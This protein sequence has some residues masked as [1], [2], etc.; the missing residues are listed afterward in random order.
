MRKHTSMP[1]LAAVVWAVSIGLLAVAVR[2]QSPTEIDAGA[3]NRIEGAFLEFELGLLRPLVLSADGRTLW[4]INQPGAEIGEW[5]RRE[6]G[7][8]PEWLRGFPATPGL[9]SLHARSEARELWAVDRLLGMVLV[10]D[11]NRGRLMRGIHVGAEPHG[12]A[13]GPEGD[14]AYVTLAGEDAVAVLDLRGRSVGDYR[15]LH[16]IAIPAREPRGIAVALDRVWVAPL[17]SGNNTA[18]R[19]R[20]GNPADT[21]VEFVNAAAGAE[22][23]LPDHD[24][25]AITITEDP[26]TDA[27]DLASSFRGLGTTLFDVVPR[28]GTSEL[29]I[30]N[31]DALN[32]EVHGERGFIR[33]QVVN[34]RITIVNIATRAVEF[35]SLDPRPESPR[36]CAQPTGITFDAAGTTAYAVGYG[37]DLVA[38]LDAAARERVRNFE[39]PSGGAWRAGPRSAVLAEGALLV[40]SKNDQGL[41]VIDPSRPSSAP[42]RLP[43]GFDP[44]PAAIKRGRGQLIDASHSASGTSSCASCHI[45]GHLDGLV[46]D[47]SLFLDTPADGRPTLPIDRKGPMLTQSLRGLSELAP[48]HWRGEKQTLHDFNGAFVGLL[49]RE[50]PLASEDMD[51][52]VAYIQ[53][54]VHPAN[55][56]APINGSLSPLAAEGKETFLRESATTCAVCHRLPLGTQNELMFDLFGG[57]SSSFKVAPLRALADRASPP[58]FVGGNFGRNGV[59]ASLGGGFLHNGALPSLASFLD[60]FFDLDAGELPGLERFLLEI[61]SGIAPAAAR[62]AEVNPHVVARAELSALQAAAHAGECDLILL[63][64]SGKLGDSGSARRLYSPGQRAF[65]GSD[66][67][68]ESISMSEVI[69]SAL[70]GE[71]SWLV[72]GVP[73]GMGARMSYDR[74]SDELADALELLIGSDSELA[75]SDGD[76]AIDGYEWRLGGNPTNPALGPLPGASAPTILSSEIL[77]RT[78]NSARLRVQT[79]LPSV[80]EIRYSGSRGPTVL[81]SPALGGGARLHSFIVAELEAG[82]AVNLE[83]TA[84]DAGGIAGAVHTLGVTPL[85]H[86][87]PEVARVEAIDLVVSNAGIGE[88][89]AL[90]V[91]HVSNRAGVPLP[92]RRVVAALYVT[93][94]GES[95]PL[96]RS[97]DALTDDGGTAR[98]EPVSLSGLKSGVI[99]AAVLDLPFEELPGVPTLFYVEA[100]DRQVLAVV[101]F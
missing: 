46:W 81:R 15:V 45:D 75:D 78:T 18:P 97:V 83:L 36:A 57:P 1:R 70:V 87:V 89:A 71:C 24:L 98:F 30:P 95:L 8:P 12:L 65:V 99:S 9:V 44:T 61:D 68:T 5:R 90:L 33:G 59:V 40:L 34:N 13:L 38:A 51:D 54:L 31:T 43:L 101:D 92:G 20:S 64:H 4:T 29:W 11:M 6:S 21:T 93:M 66:L 52:L 41:V 28:P 79:D 67:G 72:F 82:S 77:Y 63:G 17:R 73:R 27:L 96:L 7:L 39:I 37:S 14:R 84:E 100:L 49:E 23:S 91:V 50:A 76:G 80:L 42:A 85:G 94:E 35:V 22:R 86:L 53:S 69:A 48:Y 88:R 19:T 32:A 26:A 10:F 62:G 25:L 60:H 47:L 16:K 2:G 55:P 74:D 58:V 3:L 56:L